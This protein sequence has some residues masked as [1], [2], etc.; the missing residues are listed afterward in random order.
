MYATRHRFVASL[1]GAHKVPSVSRLASGIVMN[2]KQFQENILC[3]CSA[4]SVA[5]G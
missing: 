4:G 3:A 2:T 5:E 1:I